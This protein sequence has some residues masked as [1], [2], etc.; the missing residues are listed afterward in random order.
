MPRPPARIVHLGLGAFHRAHQAWYTAHAGNAREWGIVAFTGRS[1]AMA[2][3]LSGQDGLYTVIERS[4]TADRHE[5]VTS[6]AEAQDGANISR[7]ARLFASP[8]VALVTITVTEAGYRLRADGSPDTSDAA[9]GQDLAALGMAVSS[10]A[11]L[12]SLSLTTMLG[13]LLA[14]LEAR[15][16]ASGPGIAVVPCD[17]LPANGPLMSR[18]TVKAAEIVSAGLAEWISQNVSFVSTSVDR[19]TP[20][21]TAA[22]AQRLNAQQEWADAAPVVTE[23]FRD[24][25]L[26]GSF[27]AGRPAWEDAG[28][29][30]VDDIEPWER[31]KLWLLNGAHTLLSFGGLL[32]GHE[33]IAQAIGDP[34]L[35]AKVEELWDESSALLPAGLSVH[36]YRAALRERFLNS[37]IEHRLAQIAEDGTRKLSLRI[38]PVAEAQLKAGRLPDG[39]A[40]A[41]AC[42]IACRPDRPESLSTAIGSLSPSLAA[43]EA[44]VSAVGGYLSVW[45]PGRR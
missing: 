19:I 5:I 4:S 42:W 12:G 33:T 36:S 10:Q 14:G 16:R 27:P 32:R 31:R 43:H 6:L 39:A 11:Q 41:I 40:F 45:S 34:L 1:P 2:D 30:F 24:W 38:V 29:R 17:N 26:S 20:R 22:D 13:R 28:A 3:V 15:R 7:L 9:L 21:T 37:R 25:V 35:S 18:G 44:F 8:D 23:P